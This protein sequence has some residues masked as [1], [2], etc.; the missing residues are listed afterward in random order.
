MYVIGDFGRSSA[1]L[2]SAI[3][4]IFFEAGLVS[5]LSHLLRGAPTSAK[6][7]CAYRHRAPL[8]RR[9]KIVRLGR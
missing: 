5:S 8:A 4:T 2:S 6:R 3:A 9:F 7:E 1:R